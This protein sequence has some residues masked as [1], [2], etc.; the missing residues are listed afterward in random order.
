MVLSFHCRCFLD[1]Q[2]T[3]YPMSKSSENCSS[4]SGAQS[5][6]AWKHD[7][8]DGEKASNFLALDF[9]S[10]PNM[11]CTSTRCLST[12]T[13]HRERQR[14]GCS[15]MLLQLHSPSGVRPQEIACNRSKCCLQIPF[16]AC[17]CFILYLYPSHTLAQ[18]N[19]PWMDGMELS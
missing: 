7:Y 2:L 12:Y 10:G 3:A 17:L 6:S 15:R 11:F 16:S 19:V 13:T 14:D 4:S 1:H 8:S 5:Q 18:S 9:Q